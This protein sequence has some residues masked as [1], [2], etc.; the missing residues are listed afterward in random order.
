MELNKKC[1]LYISMI[2]V[3]IAILVS[4]LF[5]L[6][7]V[8]AEVGREFSQPK[9]LNSLVLIGVFLFMALYSLESHKI[10]AEE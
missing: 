3:C 1:M 7:T 4:T 6:P 10:N 2:T 5:V 9:P 8:Y